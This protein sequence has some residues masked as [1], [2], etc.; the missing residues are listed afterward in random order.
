MGYRDAMAAP[1]Y[2][3]AGLGEDGFYTKTISVYAGERHQKVRRRPL[4]QA[5]KSLARLVSK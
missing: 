1:E 3:I 2:C 5:I 4:S